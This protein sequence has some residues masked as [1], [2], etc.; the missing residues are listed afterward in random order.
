MSDPTWTC[1]KRPWA[2]NTA[3][4]GR[5]RPSDLLDGPPP[6]VRNPAAI[7]NSVRNPH[8]ESTG[9]QDGG[10]RER[11]RTCGRHRR[12]QPPRA[13]HLRVRVSTEKANSAAGGQCEEIVKTMAHFVA[14]R[15][16]TPKSVLI[17]HPWESFDLAEGRGQGLHLFAGLLRGLARIPNILPRRDV[18]PVRT[19]E[20][21]DAVVGLLVGLEDLV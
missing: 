10:T 5:R 17:L 7:P 9:R 14:N 8:C 19:P 3:S 11:C 4:G 20:G 15:C 16:H 18:G 21:P 1:G 2:L 6:G 12:P 13:W